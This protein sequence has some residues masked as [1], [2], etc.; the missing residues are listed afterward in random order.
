MSYDLVI[1]DFDGTLVD[2]AACVTASLELALSSCGCRGD[3]SQV[4]ERIGLPLEALIRQA[5]AGID[6]R[7]LRLV[8][9]AYA[10]H[11]AELEGEM[12]APFPGAVDTIGALRRAGV[13]LAIATNKLT[14]RAQLTLDRLALASQFEAIVGADAVVNPKPHPDIVVHV[15]AATAMHATSALVV[16]DT[17]WDVEMANAAGVASCAVTWGNHDAARLTRARPS[18]SADSF[19]GLVQ[20]VRPSV[21]IG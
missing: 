7:T 14:G 15:L 9:A 11:Y 10:Q 17:I 4:R 5:S 13:K 8:R 2:S 21:T 6:E 19:E 12:V 3:V 1:F 18:H 20:I 16:G